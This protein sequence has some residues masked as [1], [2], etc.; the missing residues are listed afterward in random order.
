MRPFV[1]F[2]AGKLDL[3][4][5][6]GWISDEKPVVV[7]KEKSTLPEWTCVYMGS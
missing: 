5:L 3:T 1:D 6:S 2:G 7:E 4:T